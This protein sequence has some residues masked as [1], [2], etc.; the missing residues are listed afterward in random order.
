MCLREDLHDCGPR[1]A[2]NTFGT[3]E[4][5]DDVIEAAIRYFNGA[6]KNDT[7]GS[8]DIAISA[9][10]ASRGTGKSH[11]VDELCRLGRHKKLFPDHTN[12]RLVPVPISFNGPQEYQHQ[13]KIFPD[14]QSHVIARLMHRGFFPNVP[15][16]DFTLFTRKVIWKSLHHLHFFRSMI[17]F[18][19]TLEPNEQ[20]DPVILI[21]LD[22]VMHAGADEATGMLRP[23]KDLIRNF[24]SQCRLFVTTF[25]D[26]LLNDV[27]ERSKMI[28]AVSDS[29]TDK[30][31]IE[32]KT[33][34]KT[35]V[36]FF[37]CRSL[38][39]NPLEMDENETFKGKHKTFKETHFR[40]DPL[41]GQQVAHL[42]AL[43]GGHARSLQLL[44]ETFD[45]YA[46]NA[47]VTYSDV[48]QSWF[49]EFDDYNDIKYT[50]ANDDIMLD[51]LARTL[52]NEQID[53]ADKIHGT[54]VKQL[55]RE[56]VI[57]GG[58]H[59]KD[60]FVPQ[61]SPMVLQHWSRRGSQRTDLQIRLAR[62]FELGQNLN[63]VAFEE[64]HMIFEEL[65]CWAW[66]R[67]ENSPAP[68]LGSWFRDGVFLNEGWGKKREVTIPT[69]RLVATKR[70]TET[71]AKSKETVDNI[72]LAAVRQSGMDII[73]PM[74]DL[75]FL[76]E[77][78]FSE[79]GATKNRLSFDT[80]K[81][82]ADAVQQEIQDSKMK[83]GGQ[84]LSVNNIVLIVLAHQEACGNIISRWKTENQTE[85]AF[86]IIIYDRKHLIQRYGPTF[87]LLGSFVADY[88]HRNHQNSAS[89]EE[90]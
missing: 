59:P 64:F 4:N 38:G 19:K 74:T 1:F 85:Y 47:A 62:L 23:L 42:F 24:P 32:L 17:E 37:V 25:D 58:M 61:L 39:E 63:W 34:S 82:K 57:L 43:A 28:A 41:D 52:L 54:P 5:R 69:P 49:Q 51:L 77:N 11:L 73:Q 65:R 53:L 45:A 44:K 2:N 87:E 33:G 3:T 46:H 10:L 14:A 66:H 40:F 26:L 9:T 79:H 60:N 12:K 83:V 48:F 78:K 75:T 55:I 50:N 35:P 30:Q 27:Y 7:P 22:E 67:L 71:V 8:T 15:W 72:R 88:S 76:Y 90:I 80:I 20:I 84:N 16:D 21:A 31:M 70:L 13:P 81:K 86:P 29:T 68:T 6:L 18:F 89:T 56:T 36:K